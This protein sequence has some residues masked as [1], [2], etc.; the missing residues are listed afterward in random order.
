MA[1]RNAIDSEKTINRTATYKSLALIVMI[2]PIVRGSL[3]V[4][5][6]C[7]IPALAHTPEH[8][9]CLRI[10]E[11]F[12]ET[13]DVSGDWQCG[14]ICPGHES[15]MRIRRLLYSVKAGVTFGGS[16]LGRVR[17]IQLIF[18]SLSGSAMVMWESLCGNGER[19]AHSSS[20]CRCVRCAY[21]WPGL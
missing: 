10:L 12:R 11:E 21:R 18:Q 3:V 17:S 5:A 7:I 13:G 9:L 14:Q 19:D 15:E 4:A 2:P 6:Y 1:P 8:R 20:K 16:E